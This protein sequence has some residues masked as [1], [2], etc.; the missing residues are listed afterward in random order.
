[1]TSAAWGVGACLWPG[2]AALA[3]MLPGGAWPAVQG[4]SP[5]AT[6]PAT[7]AASAAGGAPHRVSPYVLA[8]RQHALAASAPQKGVSPLTMRRPHRSHGQ[9]RSQ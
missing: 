9:P 6:V 7:A 5:G 3:L 8:A 4:A 2:L 1:M